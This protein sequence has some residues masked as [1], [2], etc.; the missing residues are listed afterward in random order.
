MH[1]QVES[2]SEMA[3]FLPDP[4]QETVTGEPFTMIIQN[5]HR[6]M[7]SPV[8][9]GNENLVYLRALSQT[10]PVTGGSYFCGYLSIGLFDLD[11][12]ADD[13]GSHHTLRGDTLLF[14]NPSRK[15]CH[16][17]YFPIQA[18]QQMT[19]TLRSVAKPHPNSKYSSN[20]RAM[21][22]G[23]RVPGSSVTSQHLAVDC[24]SGDRINSSPYTVQTSPS[25]CNFDDFDR[26]VEQF[27]NKSSEDLLPLDSYSDAA[28]TA[29]TAPFV[30]AKPA[31]STSLSRTDTRNLQNRDILPPYEDDT[32]R[33]I[34]LSQELCRQ[35]AQNDETSQVA[36]TFYCPKLQREVTTDATGISKREEGERMNC[37]CTGSLDTL[38]I[39]AEREEGNERRSRGTNN[40]VYQL[41]DRVKKCSREIPDHDSETDDLASDCQESDGETSD[42]DQYQPSLRR[43]CLRAQKSTGSKPRKIGY[44]PQLWEFLLMIL[45]DTSKRSVIGWKNKAEGIFKI[46]NSV[47]VAGLWGRHKNKKNMNYDKMSRAMRY[48]YSKGIFEKIPGRLVYKFSQNAREKYAS[49]KASFLYERYIP[50]STL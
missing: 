1:D 39:P 27:A 25:D 26:I 29:V 10:F 43:S 6:A 20:C 22:V 17:R 46:Y 34:R 5:M 4:N 49:N 41:R 12:L 21:P 9:C 28:V 32:N 42:S 13:S 50:K 30:E 2:I 47:S 15:K 18:S 45:D 37:T 16:N 7:E 48:Y 24:G 8:L 31:S 40:D 44:S 33:L 14:Q 23:Q 38:I 19:F 35:Q 11:E 36:A 3:A